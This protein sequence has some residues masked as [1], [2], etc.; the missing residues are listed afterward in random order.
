M[1]SSHGRKLA[2]ATALL[3]LLGLSDM[4]ATGQLLPAGPVPAPPEGCRIWEAHIRSVIERH[5]GGSLS[6]A[7]LGEALSIAYAA[8]GECVMCATEK[9]MN[10]NAVSALQRVQLVLSRGRDVAAAD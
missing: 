7:A 3:C 1:A 2:P 4:A 6:D 8:Y 5:K 10:E 9:E